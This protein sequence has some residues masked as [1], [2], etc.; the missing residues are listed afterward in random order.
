MSRKKVT[1]DTIPVVFMV[2]DD[3]DR[4]SIWSYIIMD[5]IRFEKRIKMFEQLFVKIKRPV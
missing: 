3:E 4:R 2:S 1:I 5:R